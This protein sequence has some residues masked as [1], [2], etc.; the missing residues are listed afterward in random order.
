MS[1]RQ[2]ARN[3]HSPRHRRGDGVKRPYRQD[4][5]ERRLV[6]PPQRSESRRAVRAVAGQSTATPPAAAF[7]P[8]ERLL[9]LALRGGV[10]A[11][12]GCIVALHAGVLNA[13][14]LKLVGH[15]G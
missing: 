10:L 3:A 15:I 12:I 2:S 7:T 9:S 8:Y 6:I 1:S 14:L 5:A 4:T 11:F 13:L